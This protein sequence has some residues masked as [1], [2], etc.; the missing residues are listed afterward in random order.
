MILLITGCTSGYRSSEMIGKTSAEIIQQYGAFDY[1]TMHAEDDG[2]YKNCRCGY[3]IRE[4]YPSFL[5]RKEEI[6]YFITFDE[7]G[8]AIKFQ[9]GYVREDKG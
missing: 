1:L 3:T 8:I 6:L 7:N 9:K 5:G 2:L 4:A